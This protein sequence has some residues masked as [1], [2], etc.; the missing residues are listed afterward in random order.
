VEQARA[1]L[2]EAHRVARQIGYSS[3]LASVLMHLGELHLA[4]REWTEANAALAEGA[5]LFEGLGSAAQ[6]L[7]VYRLLGEAALAQGDLPEAARRHAR[8]SEIVADLGSPAA[9]LT[10]LQRGEYE[11]FSGRLALYQGDW[12]AAQRWLRASAETLRGLGNRFYQGRLALDLGLLSERQGDRHRAQVQYREAA[13]LF[14]S[15]GA[16]LDAACAEEALAGVIGH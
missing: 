16:R 11:R 6:L 7:E 13:L 2:A 9:R 8:A 12:P 15:V 14:R 3:L 5:R 10:A 1:A 4:A